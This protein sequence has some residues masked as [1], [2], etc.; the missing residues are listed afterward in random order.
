MILK[1]CVK[2]SKQWKQSSDV[3]TDDFYLCPMFH[4]RDACSIFLHF[5]MFFLKLKYIYINI[6]FI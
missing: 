6:R 5:I 2:L 3:L 4:F 1:Y